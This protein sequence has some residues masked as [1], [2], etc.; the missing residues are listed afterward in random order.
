MGNQVNKKTYD[1]VTK[2][3]GKFYEWLAKLWVG[4][5]VH[6][7]PMPR[8]NFVVFNPQDDALDGETNMVKPLLPHVLQFIYNFPAVCIKSK[9]VKQIDT[10]NFESAVIQQATVDKTDS[11]R[12]FLAK[13]F[14][15]AGIREGLEGVCNG[16]LEEGVKWC[17]GEITL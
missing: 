6:G 3:A 5:E 2:D 7:Q 11:W 9:E 14:L 17:A 16:S 13:E 12:W 15:R 1:T 8:T 4:I 10:S